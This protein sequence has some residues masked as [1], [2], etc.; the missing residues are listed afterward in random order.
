M[1]SSSKNKIGDSR[2]RLKTFI[3]GVGA[4]EKT[5]SEISTYHLQTYQEPMQIIRNFK[6][7]VPLFEDIEHFMMLMVSPI[8]S[9]SAFAGLILCNYL[10]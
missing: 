8:I 2:L 7:F 5:I 9:S 6:S 10:S 4:R 3:R 1:P